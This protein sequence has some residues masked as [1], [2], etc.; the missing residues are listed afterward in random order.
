METLQKLH[1]SNSLYVEQFACHLLM[2]LLSA[3]A[4][5]KNTERNSVCLK[6]PFG[7]S[8]SHMETSQLIRIANRMT[9]FFV[10]RDFLLGGTPCEVWGFRLISGWRGFR[11]VRR[12]FIFLG[13][14]LPV[15]LQ[16]LCVLT[17]IFSL[18]V[19]WSFCILRVIS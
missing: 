10:M 3:R 13:I 16:R 14:K 5:S 17:G 12:F 11:W 7:R 6:I 8:S 2:F 19:G 18:G 15:N 4:C 9:G 1:L